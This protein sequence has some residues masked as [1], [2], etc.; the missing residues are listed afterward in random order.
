[1]TYSPQQ[2]ALLVSAVSE[3]R[4]VQGERERLA[5]KLQ[6]A[7]VDLAQLG[8]GVPNTIAVDIMS[9][10]DQQSRAL[11]KLVDQTEIGEFLPEMGI[12]APLLEWVNSL[13]AGIEECRQ[14]EAEARGRCEFWH[15]RLSSFQELE[16]SLLSDVLDDVK[17]R[18]AELQT[19]F[20]DSELW[21]AAAQ[22]ADLCVLEA[23]WN[24]LNAVQERRLDETKTIEWAEQVAARFGIPFALQAYAGRIRHRIERPSPPRLTEI[25]ADFPVAA[26]NSESDRAEAPVAV[27]VEVAEIQP[28]FSGP[29]EVVLHR[30]KSR[31]EKMS[32]ELE[33]DREQWGF[34]IDDVEHLVMDRG[35]AED[36]ARLH[37][38]FRNY[39][40]TIPVSLPE[41]RTFRSVIAEVD[42][43]RIEAISSQ[44]EWDCGTWSEDV[45]MAAEE[46][47]GK[48]VVLVGGTPHEATRQMLIDA[49]RLR[50]LAWATS[51]KYESPQKLQQL[52]QSPDVSVVF[53]LLRWVGRGHA[54]D[55]SV[56]CRS[57]RN[58]HVMVHG[59]YLPND[60]AAALLEQ[61]DS[62]PVAD[63]F[64]WS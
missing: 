33:R 48:R 10:G 38:V 36:D 6:Q 54:E 27:P 17:A 22:D 60:L 2:L 30:L 24:L 18:A 43:V 40:D 9:L 52:V 15:D 8:G 21:H 19:Q 58:R 41:S 61:T 51:G 44:G 46:L 35:V 56:Y 55:I 1:M 34:V 50:D 11:K 12:D 49:F 23:L 45:V 20:S 57:A 39:I 64:V 42:Q 31:L 4:R 5:A 14:R 32:G 29:G 37:A 63:R 59:S 16:T 13:E 53:I 28:D 47:E 25:E 26:I 62:R 7:A 3:V